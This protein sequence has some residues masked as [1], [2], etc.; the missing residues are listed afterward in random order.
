MIRRVFDFVRQD[1]LLR[2]VIKSSTH[3]FGGNAIAA[4]FS[5]FQGILLWR[6]LG[7]EGVGLV[8]GTIIVFAS[9]INT[10]LSFRM[11]ETVVRFAGASLAVGRKDQAAAIIK[12]AGLIEMFTSLLAYLVLLLLAP[13][14]ARTFA[15]DPSIAPL[16][17]FYGL[18]LLGNLVYETSSG[19]LRLTRRFNRLAQVTLGQSVLT[20]ALVCLA[21]FTHQGVFVVLTAY[22]AGKV[23]AGIAVVY[24]AFRQANHD[25]G[26]GWWR[27]PFN[28]APTRREMLS[29]SIQ[30]NLNGTLNLFTRDMVPLYLGAFW[31]TAEVGYFRQAQALLNL[32][33]LPIEPF[34]WPTFTE[35]SRTIATRQWQ[36]TRRLLKQ[37]S[38]IAAGWTI[39]AGLG[40]LLLGSWLIPLIYG[41]S[42]APVY[43]AVLILWVGYGFANIF[44]WNRP[45]LLALGKPA[46]PVMVGIIVGGVELLLTFLFVPQY[47]YLM[48][49]AILAGFFVISIGL[50][51]WRGFTLLHY[52]SKI[53]LQ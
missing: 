33:M 28:L 22:L 5:F 19:V 40:L 4:A 23:F 11:S 38:M 24:L 12:T 48:Q 17:A 36:T 35:I 37:V 34:I 30:T 50:N 27:I 2:G 39:P 8:T 14:A 41:D 31:S 16:I 51:L 15:S 21:F 20:F 49:A 9:S 3:L 7:A 52:Q 45:L 13:W 46:F 6:L 18:V 44:Q 10:L 25:L 53:T 47:G 42:A 1:G 29:F 32:V 43:P 26:H